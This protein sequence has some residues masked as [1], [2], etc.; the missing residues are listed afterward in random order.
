MGNLRDV[1]RGLV[2]PAAHE[3]LFLSEQPDLDGGVS[4][5][6]LGLAHVDEPHVGLV[7]AGQRHDPGHGGGRLHALRPVGGRQQDLV[8]VRTDLVDEGL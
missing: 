1:L 8:R 3:L 5:A 4:V 2:L 6:A 7:V